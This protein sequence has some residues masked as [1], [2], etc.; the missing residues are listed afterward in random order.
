MYDQDGIEMC[1]GVRLFRLVTGDSQDAT[2]TLD[3]IVLL[4]IVVFD[5]LKSIRIWAPQE[6]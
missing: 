3:K 2:S 5:L 6:T 4:L 1:I